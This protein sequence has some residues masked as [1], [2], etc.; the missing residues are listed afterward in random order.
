MQKQKGKKYYII[1]KKTAK[2]D[3][4]GNANILA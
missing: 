2:K 4:I 3:N 1:H